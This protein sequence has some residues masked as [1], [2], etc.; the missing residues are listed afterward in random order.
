M[1]DPRLGKKKKHALA[2]ILVLRLLV[3]SFKQIRPGML[4]THWVIPLHLK[5]I[6][7]HDC[8]SVSCFLVTLSEI[9]LISRTH[10]LTIYKNVNSPVR[11]VEANLSR[12]ERVFPYIA[13]QHLP[14]GVSTMW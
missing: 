2:A 12:T 9:S 5:R 14:F 13:T 1:L 3:A 6:V 7:F 4:G 10:N 11:S 8:L